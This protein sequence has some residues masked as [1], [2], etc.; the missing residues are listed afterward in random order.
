MDQTI[1]FA[2]LKKIDR[3]PLEEQNKSKMISQ[4][5]QFKINNW[6]GSS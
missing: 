6:K 1:F 5:L 4:L 2:F 3:L